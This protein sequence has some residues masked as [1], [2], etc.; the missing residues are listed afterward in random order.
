MFV[1]PAPP[2]DATSTAPGS[3]AFRYPDVLQDGRVALLAMPHA[4]GAT[5]WRRLQEERGGSP[6]TGPGDGGVVPILT[7]VMIQGTDA[8]VRITQGQTSQGRYAFMR[9]PGDTPRRL[10]LNMWV[11]MHATLGTIMPPEPEGPLALAGRVFAEHVFTR[12]FAPPGD[13]AVT[14]LALPGAPRLPEAIYDAPAPHA[15]ADLPQGA[16]PLG[17]TTADAPTQFSLDHCDQNQHVNSLVYPQLLIDAAVRRFATL[18]HPLGRRAARAIEIAYRRPSFAGDS[19][20][21][22][23]QCFARGDDL[24]AVATMSGAGETKPRIYGRVLFA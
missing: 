10:Y 14:E 19:I 23:L 22:S 8:R 11:D 18:G 17:A 6:M 4:L 9:S 7:R 1:F 12:P 24:G 21:L 3:A 20:T 16:T 13:R 5:V 15:S 2:V